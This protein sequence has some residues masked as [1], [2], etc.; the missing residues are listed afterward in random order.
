[1]PIELVARQIVPGDSKASLTAPALAGRGGF[2]GPGGG[3]MAAAG[4][5]SAGGTAHH[6]FRIR[7]GLDRR[8]RRRLRRRRTRRSARALDVSGNLVFAGNGYVI[9]KTKTNPY[10]GLGRQRQDHRGGRPARRIGRPAGRRR[11]RWPWRSRRP[12]RSDPDAKRRAPTLRTSRRPGAAAG[13]RQSAG[14]GL[15]GLL[16]A[17]SSTPPR[18]ARWP[19]SPSPTFSS[20]TAMA[21]PNAGARRP[22]AAPAST[23]PTYR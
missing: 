10:E 4:G 12:W 11:T 1:M 16:D 7:Q 21:N 2:G 6:Q 13:A 18:T 15:H 20:S 5:D 8:R 19:S 23:A 9:N 3:C 17:R 22:G 14:R